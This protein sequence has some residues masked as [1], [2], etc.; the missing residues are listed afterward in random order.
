MGESHE[1]LRLIAVQADAEEKSVQDP[2]TSSRRKSISRIHPRKSASAV[3]CYTW[4]RLFCFK[5][6]A[7]MDER[8]R[9]IR[10]ELVMSEI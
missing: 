1:L 9:I 7:P 8:T 4:F 5:A 3:T 6:I 10:S 2:E